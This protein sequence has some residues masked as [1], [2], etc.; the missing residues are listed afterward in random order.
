MVSQLQ[1]VHSGEGAD[2]NS[3][4]SGLQVA[5]GNDSH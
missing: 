2:L 3:L 5:L 1:P 4:P